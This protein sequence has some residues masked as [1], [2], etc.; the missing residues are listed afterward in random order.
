VDLS[1]CGDAVADVLGSSAV[2][3][4]DLKQR[5]MRDYQFDWDKILQVNGDTGVKLQYTH[6]RLFSLSQLNQIKEA[7]ELNLELLQE[8]EAK[9]LILEILRYPE[10]IINSN[11]TL[12]ACGLVN[13]LFGLW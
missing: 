10:V 13:Y 2:I 3:I 8:P 9:R 1:K 12:E 5:R 11:E 4:N 7:D 6:C